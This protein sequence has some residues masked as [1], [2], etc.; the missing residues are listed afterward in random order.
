MTAA[1]GRQAHSIYTKESSAAPDVEEATDEELMVYFRALCAT[2]AQQRK[3]VTFAY[4]SWSL[5]NEAAVVPAALSQREQEATDG[6]E[7]TMHLKELDGMFAEYVEERREDV[8][9]L[10]ELGL[11]RARVGMAARC[12]YM[13]CGA[14]M[15]AHISEDMKRGLIISV[16][17]QAKR[18]M[19]RVEREALEK[20]RLNKAAAEEAGR[21]PESAADIKSLFAVDRVGLGRNLLHDPLQ[22]GN[23]ATAFE[24]PMQSDS[25]WNVE[26]KARH[27][28][29]TLNKKASP[30]QGYRMAQDQIV[31]Q[32]SDCGKEKFFSFTML[33]GG[34]SLMLANGATHCTL[35][36]GDDDVRARRVPGVMT[37]H[38][39]QGNVVQ[40]TT[41]ANKK[42]NMV[43]VPDVAEVMLAIHKGGKYTILKNML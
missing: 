16:K 38:D 11:A 2:E 34:N 17:T 6:R 8:E 35:P 37:V 29:A 32:D 24:M 15:D 13:L 21:E 10:M 3:A 14:C 22:E 30:M 40:F 4:V 20:L 33:A 18:R 27:L 12:V 28:Q 1:G 5:A 26:L 23:Q 42:A 19:E 9:Y 25:K 41:S 39:K 7:I 31:E 43:V 36:V